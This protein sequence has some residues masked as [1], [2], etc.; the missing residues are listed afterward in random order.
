MCDI[1]S[2][3]KDQE[4]LLL[5]HSGEMQLIIEINDVNKYR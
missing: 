3:I 5:Q 2:L 4:K 1:S